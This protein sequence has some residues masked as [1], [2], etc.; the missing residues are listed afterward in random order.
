MRG[1]HMAS[2][3]LN[4]LRI[5]DSLMEEGSA[6]RAGARLGLS[7]SAVSHALNRLRH[8]LDDELFVRTGQGLM[9]TAKARELGPRIHAALAEVQAAL[10]P[11]AF[12]A[13]TSERRFVMMGGGYFCGVLLPTLVHRVAAVAPGVQL[14]VSDPGQD[15]LDQLDSRRADFILGAVGT[16]P[17]RLARELALRESLVWI[18][19]ADHPLARGPVSLE[20]LVSVP[21]VS[22]GRERPTYEG[23]VMR[24]TWEDTG[25][26]E[27]EL[28]RLGLSRRVG[29]TV[30][31]A[32]SALSVVRRS[33]MAALLPRRLARLTAQSGLLALIEPPYPSATV[34]LSLLYLR[35]RLSEPAVAWMREQLLAAALSID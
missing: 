19:R 11:R 17:P 7:Q 1:V 4:L 22:I 29:V 23:L 25:S 20:A 28:L 14:V 18:V 16:A 13:A 10:T 24:A 34:D 27:A 5:F 15:A 3:D 33:D 32:F 2:V 30:P 9:P 26:L 8:A 21:H 12:D 35:E 6:T 31:D